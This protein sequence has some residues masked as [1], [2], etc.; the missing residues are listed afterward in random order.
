[1]TVIY[2]EGFLLVYSRR[3]GIFETFSKL[4]TY[5]QQFKIVRQFY[6]LW[7]NGKMLKCIFISVLSLNF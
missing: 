6:L 4:L 3:G 2:T 5:L 7:T 1:M